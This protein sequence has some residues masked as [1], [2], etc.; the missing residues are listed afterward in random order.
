MTRVV[1]MRWATVVAGLGMVAAFGWSTRVGAQIDSSGCSARTLRG[2]YAFTI[3]GEVGPARTPL[4]AVAMTTFDGQGALEQVDFVT[5]NG[6]PQ[7]SDWRRARGAYV[8]NR[9]CTGAMVT[10]SEDGSPGLRL[11]LVVTARGEQIYNVV[12]GNPVGAVGTR[13]R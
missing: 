10:T 13:V 9:D 7:M 4:R 2:E 1:W 6:V 11:R 5:L 3:T 12:E 8:V